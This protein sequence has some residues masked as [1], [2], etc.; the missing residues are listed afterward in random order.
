MLAR[1]MWRQACFI[2]QKLFVEMPEFYKYKP[3]QREKNPV[4]KSIK[5][6]CTQFSRPGF[7]LDSLLPFPRHSPFRYSLSYKP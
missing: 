2:I 4:S 3:K 6:K 1:F 5:I 7:E